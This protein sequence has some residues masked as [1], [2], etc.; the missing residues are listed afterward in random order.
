M[1]T[2]ISQPDSS[3]L[4][5][6]TTYTSLRAEIRKTMKA[7]KLRAQRAVEREKVRT[8]WEIGKLILAHVLRDKRAGYG[9]QVITRL[10]KDLGLSR[11]ELNRMVEFARAYPIVAPARQLPWTSYVA[12]LSVNDAAER[13][14]LAKKAERNNWTRRQLRRELKNYKQKT[15][16]L[17]SSLKL[18]E[19][20]RAEIGKFATMKPKYGEFKGK[21]VY[22]LGFSVFY[23]PA[24]G[25]L[26]NSKPSYTYRA[27]VAQVVDGD[28]FWA[29]I[30][31][32]FG[33]NTEQKLRLRGIDAPELARAV[34]E[35]AKR[36]LARKLKA[37]KDVVIMSSRSDK[38]DRYLADVWIDNVYLNQLLV[39]QGYA[40][41][42][43][44]T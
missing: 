15:D 14:A 7:G 36:Y 35:R 2:S 41:V 43:P 19:P 42:V 37:A 11:S 21:L 9:A 23:K 22:D 40:R 32:G 44:A 12:L 16:I 3:K 4:A 20:K 24:K 10:S 33:V 27:S 18:M 38:Y 6:P 30:H 1:T 8:S 31:L 5:V 17:D 28:T 34:G 26:K 29:F 39:D 25:R 13:N